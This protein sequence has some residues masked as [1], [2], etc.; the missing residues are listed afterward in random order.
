MLFIIRFRNNTSVD[1][2]GTSNVDTLWAYNNFAIISLE[3][4][5][6]TKDD[7]GVEYQLIATNRF[8]QT[9]STT[10]LNVTCNSSIN[11]PYI[12]IIFHSFQLNLF[13]LFLCKIKL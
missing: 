7:N 4:G 10:R 9:S 2:K 3:L 5:N 6:S 12:R 8:G 1:I 11:S 13:S